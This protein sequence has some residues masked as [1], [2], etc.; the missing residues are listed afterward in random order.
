MP[1][2]G[3]DGREEVVI[4][5]DAVVQRCLRQDGRRGDVVEPDY[6]KMQ[7]RRS[8]GAFVLLI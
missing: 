3:E 8:V 1:G 7:A 2:G 5:G 4:T 6:G